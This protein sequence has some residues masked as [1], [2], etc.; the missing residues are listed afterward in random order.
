VIDGETYRLWEPE[1]DDS[2]MPRRVAFECAGAHVE[3]GSGQLDAEALLSFA[4]RFQPAR[5]D[6]PAL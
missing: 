2:L 5:T 1:E 6:P 4:G 3:L